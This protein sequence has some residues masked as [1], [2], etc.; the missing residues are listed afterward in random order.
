[1]TYQEHIEGIREGIDKL[2]AMILRDIDE[3]C[4]SETV[5]QQRYSELRHIDEGMEQFALRVEADIDELDMDR[6]ANHTIRYGLED[7]FDERA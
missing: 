5:L 1:M 4:G 6:M 2:K 7:S 3:S